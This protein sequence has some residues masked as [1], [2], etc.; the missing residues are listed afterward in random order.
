[1]VV[2]LIGFLPPFWKELSRKI[3]QLYVN[4][5]G[6]PNLFGVKPQQVE[7]S[8]SVQTLSEKAQKWPKD[9]ETSGRYRETRSYPTASTG[10][11]WDD[12]PWRIR[13]KEK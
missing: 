11:V 4:R 10:R 8:N 7:E 1:M 13:G 12:K 2:P 5:F 9:K 6:V 3:S